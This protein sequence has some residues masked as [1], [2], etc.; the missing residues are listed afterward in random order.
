[1]KYAIKSVAAASLLLGM[2]LTA[3]AAEIDKN[4]WTQCGIGAMIFQTWQPGAA[5][6]NVIW[7]LG[8]TAVTSASSSPNTCSGK[9]VVAARFIGE[10]YANIEE[11]TV[12]GGGQHVQAMLSILECDAAAQPELTQAI[13]DEFSNVLREPSYQNGDTQAKAEAYYNVVNSKVAGVCKIG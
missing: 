11:E 13:R 12:K 3:S 4:P 7:D 8:T 2:P 6:S 1:M 9:D 10:N 5:I